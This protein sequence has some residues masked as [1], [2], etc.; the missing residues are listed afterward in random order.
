MLTHPDPAA[1][2]ALAP[3]CTPL[4][5]MATDAGALQYPQYTLHRTCAVFQTRSEL[6]EYEE[7]LGRAAQLADALEA[8]RAGLAGWAS[9]DRRN[10]STAPPVALRAGKLLLSS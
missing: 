6:L 2:A 7:A 4:Q 5:F 9:A 8:S 3:P 1:C 10:G